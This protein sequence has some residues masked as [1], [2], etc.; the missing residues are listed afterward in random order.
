MLVLGVIAYAIHMYFSLKKDGKSVF[1]IE[2]SISVSIISF[3]VMGLFAFLFNSLFH[4]IE[5]GRI[6]L[7]GITWAGGVVGAFPAF[8]I[9]THLLIKE[10]RGNEINFFSLVVPGIVLGH[11]FGR[12]GCFM[13]G[14]CYGKE[15]DGFLSVIF[16]SLTKIVLYI[17]IFVLN[18][19]L[20]YCIIKL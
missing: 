11:A 6:V 1:V 4:S 20:I 3:A 17:A 9:I 2:K 19:W 15:V 12:I 14:C 18:E 10:E 13:A 8:V 7:G 5:E 16:K